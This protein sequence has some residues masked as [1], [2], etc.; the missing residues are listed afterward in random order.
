MALA[1][2]AHD[3]LEFKNIKTE[4]GSRDILSGDA[5]E[6]KKSGGVS[7]EKWA[8]DLVKNQIHKGGWRLADLLEE[9]L[10]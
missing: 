8:S 7:Y 2:E 1:R 6:K 5:V 9:A 10:K 4:A 3:R